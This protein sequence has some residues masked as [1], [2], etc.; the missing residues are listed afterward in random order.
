MKIAQQF[1]I[2]ALTK[3]K[4]YNQLR[5]KKTLNIAYYLFTL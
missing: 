2:Q 5:I 4:F 1:Y 3:E